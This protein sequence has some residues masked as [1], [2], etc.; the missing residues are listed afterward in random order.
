MAE[1]VHLLVNY[2][3]KH[4][5]LFFSFFIIAQIPTEQIHSA[6]YLTCSEFLK[7][8]FILTGR[9][10]QSTWVVSQDGLILH[11]FN[12]KRTRLIHKFSPLSPFAE[13]KQVHF[14]H[15]SQSFKPAVLHAISLHA[16]G[17]SCC[18]FHAA[19]ALNHSRPF[20]PP[21]LV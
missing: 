12:S 19:H 4:S 20:L 8:Y 10:L 14:D 15:N 18:W 3:F 7:G 1:L 6:K 16:H 2:S 13:L 17:N 9:I 11:G 21:C 5:I